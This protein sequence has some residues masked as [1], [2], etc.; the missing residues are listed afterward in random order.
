MARERLLEID[1]LRV[2]AI[3]IVLLLIHLHDYIYIFYINLDRFGFYL[4]NHISIYYSIGIFVFLSGFGLHLQKHNRNINTINKLSLFFKRRFFGI[5]PVYW[6]AL[7]LFLIVFQFLGIIHI[8][9]LDSFELFAHFFGLQIFFANPIFTLWFIGLIVIYYCIYPIISY[10]TYSQRKMIFPVSF[11]IF[12]FF[13]LV[14]F[15]IDC[16]INIMD[17]RFFIYYFIFITGIIAADIYENSKLLPINHKISKLLMNKYVLILFLSALLSILI[18]LFLVIQYYS[19]FQGTYIEVIE[20]Q[21]ESNTMMSLIAIIMVNMII[22]TFILFL[23]SVLIIYSKLT[24]EKSKKFSEIQSRFFSKLAYSSFCVYL[25]HRPIFASLT[26]ILREIFHIDIYSI[27][28]VLILSIPPMFCLAF[29]IQFSVDTV[30]ERVGAAS[31]KNA[32][33]N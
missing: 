1:I 11:A 4:V 3:L 10:T 25:F 22:I 31:R 17:S 7:G 12:I 13:T 33:L 20:D 5:Y 27:T 15:I 9:N 8:L 26:V 30:L 2:I 21:T 19:T 23:F 18:N 29:L 6:I 14:D 16:I 32:Y 24:S 28:I